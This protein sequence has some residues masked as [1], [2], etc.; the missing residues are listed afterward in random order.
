MFEYTDRSD[1]GEG[2]LGT[3]EFET[4]LR[5]GERSIHSVSIKSRVSGIFSSLNPTIEGFYALSSFSKN[6]L[7][8]RRENGLKVRISHLFRS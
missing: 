7:Q 5:I 3:F 4:D 8:D 1:L 2:Q 6:A